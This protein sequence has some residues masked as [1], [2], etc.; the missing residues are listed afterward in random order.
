MFDQV[1][2]YLDAL[3]LLKV[4]R[5]ASFI[6][7][8]AHEIGAVAGA[9]ILWVAGL[10][11]AAGVDFKERG[12]PFSDV[13]SFDP[14]LNFYNLRPQIRQLQ[15]GKGADEDAARINDSEAGEGGGSVGGGEWSEGG[16][17]EYWGR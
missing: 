11:G 7:I 4:D 9:L 13:V 15:R 5:D 14:L 17:G 16:G 3:G 12:S 10:L 2:Y 1:V 8:Q 6:P